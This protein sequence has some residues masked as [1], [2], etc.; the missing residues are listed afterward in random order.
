L[1]ESAKIDHLLG[2]DKKLSILFIYEYD[3]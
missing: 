1:I 2:E 3:I